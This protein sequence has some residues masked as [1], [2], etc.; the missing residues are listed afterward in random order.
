LIAWQRE[1]RQPEPSFRGKSITFWLERRNVSFSWA[2]DWQLHNSSDECLLAIGPPAIPYLISALRSRDTIANRTW[3]SLWPKLPGF[4][5]DPD[6]YATS[7]SWKFFK[8]I[9]AAELRFE[10]VNGLGRLFGPEAAVAVPDL[11]EALHDNNYSIRT[12]AAL[13]L[14]YIGS[15][16]DAAAPE[17]INSLND[18]AST[19]GTCL[20]SG[21]V[22]N[23]RLACLAGLIATG[24]NSRDAGVVFRKLLS[25]PELKVRKLAAAGLGETLVDKEPS[26]EALVKALG[27][28]DAE[29]RASVIGA[30]GQIGAASA[31]AVPQLLQELEIQKRAYEVQHVGDPFADGSLRNVCESL[32][33]IGPAAHVA[34]PFLIVCATN[35]DSMISF[36]GARALWA[37]EPHNAL[38]IPCLIDKLKWTPGAEDNFEEERKNA[39]FAALRTLIKIGPEARAGCALVK[40]C[41]SSDKAESRMAAVVAAWRLDGNE[42]RPFELLENSYR[43]NGFPHAAILDVIGDLGPAARDLLS[44]VHDAT[45]DT[46]EY[47]RQKAWQTLRRVES[48]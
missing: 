24:K 11:I 15:G 6:P 14:G 45:R 7:N 40:Q 34:V 5:R 30:L 1:R 48:R 31:C 25:D 37:V 26:V 33:K 38:T 2:N 39:Q 8:P 47:I 9:P 18:P 22:F 16:A 28:S 20:A 27:D 10:A 3:V 44:T 4:M 43:T 29:V 17:L 23:L 19:N 12:A 42:P 41:A 13:A 36:Y 32:E 35:A 21:G 46:D